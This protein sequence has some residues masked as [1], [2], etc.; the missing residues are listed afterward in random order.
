[1]TVINGVKTAYLLILDCP[2]TRNAAQSKTL[3]Y[4]KQQSVTTRV[5]SS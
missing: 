4:L 3:R 5:N 1:M 2:F